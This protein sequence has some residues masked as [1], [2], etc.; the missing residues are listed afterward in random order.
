MGLTSTDLFPKRPAG[1]VPGPASNG[2]PREV[3]AYDYT[4][5]AG[6]L[7]YQTVRYD[8][9]EFRPRRPDGR[10]GWAW[11]LQG[12]RRVL[13]RLPEPAEDLAAGRTVLVVEG[14]KAGG[15]NTPRR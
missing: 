14:E 6:S 4:D 9:K 3:S 2:R 10:G 5:A 15:R 1:G 7:L 11:S 8:P 12:V 13:Y